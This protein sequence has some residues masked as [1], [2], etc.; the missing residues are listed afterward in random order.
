MLKQRVHLGGLRVG[1]QWMGKTIKKKRR[2]KVQIPAAQLSANGP[3]GLER[4]GL[5]LRDKETLVDDK[6]YFTLMYRH[7]HTAVQCIVRI[8]SAISSEHWRNV[9]L[10]ASCAPETWCH[11]NKMPSFLR[12]TAWYVF[13]ATD[14]K[15]R[16]G[17][18]WEK[19]KNINKRDEKRFNVADVRDWI[20]KW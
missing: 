6:I 20:R 19:N 17:K 9:W 8:S 7:T 15:E 1:S 13:R 16:E 2:G 11:S 3:D 18:Q 12:E 14:W 4:E 5:W 10:S